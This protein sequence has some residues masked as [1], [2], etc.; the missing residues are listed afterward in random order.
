VPLLRLEDRLLYFR[1]AIGAFI[2][3][4]D[5]RHAPMWLDIAHEHWKSNA[6]RTN[7]E[8]RLNIVVMMDIGW[9]VGNSPRKDSPVTLDPNHSIRRGCKSDH[10]L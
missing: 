6:A 1:A 3:E 9:H 7:D 5:L 10:E 8:S 4:F 2:G